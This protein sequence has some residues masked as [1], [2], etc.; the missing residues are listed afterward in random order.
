MSKVSTIQA[1]FEACRDEITK[2]DE[3]LSEEITE[4]ETKAFEESRSITDSETSRMDDVDSLRSILTT[5]LAALGLETLE[6]IEA[7]S[8]LDSVLT[9]IEG[10]NQELTEELKDLSKVAKYT[11]KVVDI[12]GKISASA[13][14]ICDVLA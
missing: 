9:K 4:I 1:S 6:A 3:L 5:K 13:A 7:S 14:K 8:G 12:L 2:L 11:E 10:I